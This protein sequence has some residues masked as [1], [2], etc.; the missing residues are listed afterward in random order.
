VILN[1]KASFEV[2]NTLRDISSRNVIAKVEGT[3][4]NLKN[5]YFIYTAHWDHLGRDPKL[6]GD[7][8]YNGALDNATGTAALLELAEAFTKVQPARTMLFLSVTAEEKGLLGAKYYAT[9]PLYPLERTL[10]NINMDGVNVWGRTRDVGIVGLGQSTLE[11]TLAGFV[12]AQGRVLVPEAEPEKGSYFRSD[13]FE[14]ARQGVP[15]LYTDK[16]IDFIGKPKDFGRQKRAEYTAN[17][18]HKV[19]DEIKPD[20]DLSG[21]VEDLH[22]LF[23]VGYAVSQ[24]DKRP[25]WKAGSEFKARRRL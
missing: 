6:K 8:I 25:E 23:E 4:P 17:D 5:E 7:Q 14:F 22:L 11:D 16:G 10:A 9:H 12:A 1:A 19:T 24:G 2:R 20:W 3:D 18:Y 13:H 15:A 21:A